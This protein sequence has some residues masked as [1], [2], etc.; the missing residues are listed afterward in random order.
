MLS[1][2]LFNVFIN[3]ADEYAV[4]KRNIITFPN[5][6][7]VGEYQKKPKTEMNFSKHWTVF[8]P[9]PNSEECTLTQC[10]GT[11]AGT[12]TGTGTAGTVSF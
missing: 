10:C 7:T 2:C 11:G 5:D 3:G 4:E 8:V 6:T 9:G 1:S 12:G